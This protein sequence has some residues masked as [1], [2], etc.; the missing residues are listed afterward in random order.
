MKHIL[1]P[2]ALV[3]VFLSACKKSADTG[4]TPDG[5]P[6]TTSDSFYPLQ[7]GNYWT[8]DQY[9]HIQVTDTLRVNGDLYYKVYSL[10]GGDMINIQYLRIDASQNLLQVDPA[11]PSKI[12]V[13]AK[14]NANVNDTFKTLGD[15]S[16][17]DFSVK[18]TA[19]S[20][21][22]ITFQ[23]SYPA[24]NN[25]VNPVDLSYY[26]GIGPFNLKLFTSMKINGVVYNLK[27]N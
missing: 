5:N 25:T 19:K 12:M 9:T 15:N 23:T 20:A 24:P 16:A 18:L 27:G 3:L 6:I 10:F 1:L 4:L 7:V 11:H 13:L 17:F 26:K 8:I 21:T 22:K 2:L 14:F